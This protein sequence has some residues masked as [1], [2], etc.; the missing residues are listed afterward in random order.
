MRRHIGR[1]HYSGVGIGDSGGIT[2]VEGGIK[3]KDNSNGGEVKGE[4]GNQW[5]E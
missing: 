1:Y 5:K 4:E 3:W 2:L